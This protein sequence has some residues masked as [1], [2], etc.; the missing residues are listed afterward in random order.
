MK[1][2]E[3]NQMKLTPLT[4]FEM[5]QTDG[6]GRV[7]SLGLWF[8]DQIV[9]NWDEIKRGLKDGWNAAPVK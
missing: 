6:G 4:E 3:F 8:I 9:S 1:K 5:K 7:S 2:L